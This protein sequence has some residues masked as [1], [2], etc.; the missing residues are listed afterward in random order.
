[1]LALGGLAIAWFVKVPEAKQA[2]RPEPAP[3][4]RRQQPLQPAPVQ[5]LAASASTE[6]PAARSSP[7]V[8]VMPD[9]TCPLG[10]HG[11]GTLPSRGRPSMSWYTRADQYSAAQADQARSAAPMLVYFYT[12]WC[13]YCRRLERDLLTDPRIESYLRENVV[14]VKIN[15]E[16]DAADRQ[17]ERQFG[18]EGYPSLFVVMPMGEAED[19]SAYGNGS[20]L[21]LPA[22][23][24]A[25][26]EQ[27]TAE[28]ADRLKEEGTSARRAG[29]LES[30]I[31]KL[32]V[33]AQ[34][35]PED[36]EIYVERGM[37]LA[38]K[39]AFNDALDDLARASRLAPGDTTPIDAVEEMLSGAGRQSEVVA[40]WSQ[41]IDRN[42]SR[43]EGYLERARALQNLGLGTLSGADFE[44]ACKL[45]ERT[46]CPVFAPR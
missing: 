46:A 1:M 15:P 36:P 42:P 43:A 32:T 11:Q 45:G 21:K 7:D 25:G 41:Y 8:E 34:L 30:A 13:P 14:K 38:K 9:A 22:E 16:S 37:A 26:I 4:I 19:Y 28:H 12:D 29:D 20:R 39:Q 40:C 6:A 18:S 3:P 17:L 23:F 33:A 35:H 2:P 27:L 10:A 31:A 5:Q 44:R 24:V